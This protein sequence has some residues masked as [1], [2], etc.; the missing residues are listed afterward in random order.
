MERKDI[1]LDAVEKNKEL[2][3]NA[4]RWLWAHPQTG[5]TEWQAHEYLVS[6][7]QQLGYEVIPAGNIPGFY[8]DVDTGKKGPTLY[9]MGELDALDIANHKEA[10]DGM[11]HACGHHAQVSAL[12]GI[13]AALKEDGMLDG[14]CGKIRL[15]A[16]PAEEMIQLDYRESLL[17]KGDPSACLETIRFIN[18]W[19]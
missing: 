13:A 8:T 18:L 3:L 11:S 5:Y 4:E 15:V 12:L 16:V 9:I 1:I 7:F 10:V 2:V 14:M 17:Q 6:K 19:G